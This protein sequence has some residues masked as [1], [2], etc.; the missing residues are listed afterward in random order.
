MQHEKLKRMVAATVVFAMHLIYI[1]ILTVF[2]IYFRF[3]V[4]YKTALKHCA[5]WAIYSKAPIN[6]FWNLQ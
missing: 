6:R 5:N 1:C 4:N 3:F 2:N